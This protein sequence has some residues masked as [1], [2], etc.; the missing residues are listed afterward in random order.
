MPPKT[1]RVAQTTQHA[2]L[3]AAAVAWP[4][5][6]AGLV[7]GQRVGTGCIVRAF[8]PLRAAA[9]DAHHFEVP[10]AEFA[11]TEAALRTAGHPWLGFVHSH[12]HG[13]AAPSHKDLA[14][15]W[16]DC[17]QLVVAVGP[18]TTAAVGAFWLSSRGAVALPILELET[19]CPR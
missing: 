9:C 18:G 19:G 8:A 7:G 12:P 11:A 6:M 14:E 2:M 10:A 13:T 17:L 1:V 5:E 15:L 3:A 16:H 4:R